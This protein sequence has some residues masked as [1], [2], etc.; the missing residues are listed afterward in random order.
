MAASRSEKAAE[1]RRKLIETAKKSFS[2]NGYNGTSVRDIS[3]SIGVSESL[4]YHYFPNGKR[5]LLSEVMKK[6]LSDFRENVPDS[7]VVDI[8]D[9]LPIEDSLK[10]IY[11]RLS[12]FINE[13]IDL[14]RIVILE[15]EVR[16]FIR[17][18]DMNRYLDGV[19]NFLRDF[20][21]NRMDKGEIH[22][23][24]CRAAALVMRSMLLNM[25]LFSVLGIS[26][27]N[28]VSENNCKEVFLKILN[29][30]KEDSN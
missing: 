22:D 16:D 14:I 12:G 17:A 21:Q 19:E 9:G 20:L 30:R 11:T 4:L 3:K 10:S 18:E 5:E 13:H 8:F 1:T 2:E 28:E 23:V 24:D 7:D 25:V 27:P 6:E 15:K 26:F 29:L